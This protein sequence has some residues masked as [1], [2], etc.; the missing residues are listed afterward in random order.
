MH[1]MSGMLIIAAFG[2][3]LAGAA[4]AQTAPAAQWGIDEL[5]QNL[6]RVKIAK[7]KFV[8]A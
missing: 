2:G 4:A 6:A 1:R 5:M 8:D 7:A 3:L